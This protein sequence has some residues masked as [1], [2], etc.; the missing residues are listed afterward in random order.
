MCEI[1][2]V[3]HDRHLVGRCGE[4]DRAERRARVAAPHRG[5]G[6]AGTSEWLGE[7]DEVWNVSFFFLVFVGGNFLGTK[8][9]FCKGSCRSTYVFFDL[10]KPNLF[11][12]LKHV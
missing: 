7:V 2:S 4:G 10:R 3:L 12:G 6:R 1:P 8:P 9:F 11:S 5:Q